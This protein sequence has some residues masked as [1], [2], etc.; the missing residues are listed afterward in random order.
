MRAICPVPGCGKKTLARDYCRNH[1]YRYMRHGTP[2][3][4]P[5]AQVE[6]SRY[7]DRLPTEGTECITWPFGMKGDGRG[8]YRNGSASRY[9]CEK[10]HGPRPTPKHQ[11]AH[12]CGKGHEACIAPYHLSW[13]TPKEN[14]QDR[15]IH[16]T[17]FLGSKSNLAKLTESEVSVIKSLLPMK[18]RK[19][20]AVQ[21][22]VSIATIGRIAN[23][24]SWAHVR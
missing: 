12:S 6:I 14:Q 24:S 21:F 16:G 13:K 10:F 7:I 4:G 11:A 1:Y 18:S 23:G 5:A 19:D 9:I 8:D 2:T 15:R 17:A 20:I 3:G 22:G